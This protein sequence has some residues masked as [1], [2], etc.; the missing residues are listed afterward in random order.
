MNHFLEKLDIL[1]YV[2]RKLITEIHFM[3]NE[4]ELWHFM[5]TEPDEAIQCIA[6]RQDH[7]AMLVWYSWMD[8]TEIPLRTMDSMPLTAAEA[9]D[10]VVMQ[11]IS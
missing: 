9:P 8:W 11:G 3:Y 2:L 4:L 1:Y 10:M 7:L 5:R 6:T